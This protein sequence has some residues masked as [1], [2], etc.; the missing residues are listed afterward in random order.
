MSFSDSF[1]MHFGEVCTKNDPFSD[2][3]STH[4]A[5]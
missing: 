3:L 4:F 2:G 5:E 1:S